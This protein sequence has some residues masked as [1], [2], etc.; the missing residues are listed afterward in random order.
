MHSWTWSEWASDVASLFSGLP[1]K[2]KEKTRFKDHQ[3]K[4]GQNSCKHLSSFLLEVK[5]VFQI[6]FSPVL[7][8]KCIWEHH[9]IPASEEDALWLNIPSYHAH[10]QVSLKNTSMSFL[11]LS[12]K[13]AHG[14][15][16][17]SSTCYGAGEEV[18]LPPL[19]TD[20]LVE[21]E[22][23][24]AVLGH[25][26]PGLDRENCGQHLRMMSQCFPHLST[27]D[28]SISLILTI[29]Y[30]SQHTAAQE[31]SKNCD[32]GQH[33]IEVCHPLGHRRS[34]ARLPGVI[35][36]DDSMPGS[37]F[38]NV[39]GRLA[40]L[41][42]FFYLIH[43]ILISMEPGLSQSGLVGS[44]AQNWDSH[45]F[46]NN[47]SK[48]ILPK[49]S[50]KSTTAKAQ[51]YTNTWCLHTYLFQHLMSVPA[52][53]QRGGGAPV[54]VRKQREEETYRWRT[55]LKQQVLPPDFSFLFSW[56]NKRMNS[57]KQPEYNKKRKRK[58]KRSWVQFLWD[59][60]RNANTHREFK[61]EI[62][63]K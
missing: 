42:S 24:H 53:N 35:L 17:T 48:Q 26:V 63:R 11:T 9:R 15:R 47:I 40:C 8:N 27:C 34:S 52:L 43:L 50:F 28:E 4:K 36:P 29:T 32:V 13:H 20:W 30:R 59:G 7:K 14:P 39:S 21:E 2:I 54:R 37:E 23:D 58:R 56:L 57:G 44:T 55:T 31:D 49:R 12:P 41:T 16:L 10:C 61:P 6:P 33:F 51:M 22:L 45:T 25:R 38:S 5:R 60:P 1:W 46:N 3:N 19:M 62:P 18:G